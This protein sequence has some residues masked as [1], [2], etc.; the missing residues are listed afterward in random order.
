M[1]ASAK[2]AVIVLIPVALAGW[3]VGVGGVIL[4]LL[5][6]VITVSQAVVT[7][8][9]TQ[10]LFVLLIGVVAAL[11]PVAHQRPIGV[12]VVVGLAAI[13]S[14]PGNLA[15]AGLLALAPV[16][17]LLEGIGEIGL[18]SW[19]ALIISLLV[20][21]YVLVVVRI[22]RV[23]LPAHPTSRSLAARHAAAL[24]ISCVGFAYVVAHH[25]FPHGYWVIATLAVV[26]RPSTNESRNVARTR[27]VGTVVGALIAVVVAVTLPQSLAVVAS[28]V[29]VWL[30]VGYTLARRTLAAVVTT[31]VLIITVVSASVSG[32]T[33]AI[34]GQRLLWTFVGATVAVVLGLFLNEVDD[35]SSDGTSV[36]APNSL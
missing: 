6:V 11:G 32:D 23:R 29:M 35:A 21:A 26:L 3:A 18:A 16:V 20:G 31:S 2:I 13:L 24:A 22:M 9:P 1:A 34:A 15:S 33:V 36:A 14:Y 4:S 25:N 17:A 19:Q 10:S 30:L 12:A 8:G 5:V 27:I 28:G 7:R